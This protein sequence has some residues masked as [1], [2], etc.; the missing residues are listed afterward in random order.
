MNGLRQV[1]DGP[2]MRLCL[3]LTHDLLLVLAEILE[4]DW[5]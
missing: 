3:L 4:L 1:V 2:R 5:E